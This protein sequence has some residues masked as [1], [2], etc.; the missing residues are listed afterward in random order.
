MTNK[1][2]TLGNETATAWSLDTGSDGCDEA[3]LTGTRDE[4]MRDV[5]HNHDLQ[6]WPG[7]W[8]LAEKV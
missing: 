5:M 6:T 7:H 2:T 8:E 4:V 1:R 3:D